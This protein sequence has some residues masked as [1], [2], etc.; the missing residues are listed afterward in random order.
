MLLRQLCREPDARSRVLSAV[1]RCKLMDS[2]NDLY[3][4]QAEHCRRMADA[5][6]TEQTKVEWLMLAERWLRMIREEWN[7]VQAR[8]PERQ[9]A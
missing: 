2:R 3:F 4:K 1:P 5:A 7:V 9:Q 8:Q 6:K